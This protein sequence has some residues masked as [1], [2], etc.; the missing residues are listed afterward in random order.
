MWIYEWAQMQ[1]LNVKAREHQINNLAILVLIITVYLRYQSRR[2]YYQRWYP[3]P[4]KDGAVLFTRHPR[5]FRMAQNQRTVGIH[6]PV[7]GELVWI[8]I[9]AR[10]ILWRFY[11]R[12]SMER[13]RT[14][15]GRWYHCTMSK[16]IVLELATCTTFLQLTNSHRYL[17]LML[18][19]TGSSSEGHI[20]SGCQFCWHWCRIYHRRIT[21]YW[22]KAWRLFG[23]SSNH[24]CWCDCQCSFCLAFNI[25]IVSFTLEF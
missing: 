5:V 2:W 22:R 3:C 8:L 6:W 1:I 20:T 18:I 25:S 19:V 21:R 9:R 14:Y 11:P 23:T 24:N 16:D 12:V 17:F 4:N 7:P 10:L 13:C 15:F